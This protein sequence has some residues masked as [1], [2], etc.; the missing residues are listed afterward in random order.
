MQCRAA[1]PVGSGNVRPALQQQSACI[2]TPVERGP[3]KGSAFIRAIRS[4]G[5]GAATEKQF[6][7]ARITDPGS[8]RQRHFACSVL[9]VGVRASIEEKGNYFRHP[10]A[11]GKGQSVPARESVELE[12]SPVIQQTLDYRRMPSPY[13]PGKG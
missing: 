6:H 7:H 1:E 4:I 13:G 12:R 9:I 8:H 10:R 5:I 11:G 3:E 2:D